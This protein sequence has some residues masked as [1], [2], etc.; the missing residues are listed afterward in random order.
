[1]GDIKFW[2][3]RSGQELMSLRR[4]SAPVT[5]I[6]FAADGKMLITGTDG[7]FAVWDA[8]SE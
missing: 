8:R 3:V 1:M 2:D 5:V 6:E 7:E 4:H